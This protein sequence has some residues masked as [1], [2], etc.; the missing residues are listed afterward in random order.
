MRFLRDTAASYREPVIIELG[1]RAGMST[2]CFLAAAEE[3]GG[4]VWSA[5]IAP[6]QVPP[7]WHGLACW[8]FL[9]A[10]DVSPEC[11]E[12]MPAA[13]DVV[14]IDTSHQYGHTLAELGAYVPRVRPGGVILLHD[15][16]WEQTGDSPDLC[17]QLDAPGGTVTAALDE[18]AARTGMAWE[19]RHGCYGIGIIRKGAP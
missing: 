2:S 15:T 9:Q 18:W 5:D 10:D 1:V 14:F 16:E 8:H 4:Q 13:C 12:W 17:R 19:N 6:A 3:T 11:L 7:H